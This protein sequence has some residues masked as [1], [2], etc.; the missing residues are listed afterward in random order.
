MLMRPK[1][2]PPGPRT[3]APSVDV[4]A[5]VSSTLRKMSPRGSNVC[6]HE[7]ICDHL[8]YPRT[9]QARGR[10][11]VESRPESSRGAVACRRAAASAANDASAG[12][13]SARTY[14]S[15]TRSV[16]GAPS[17]CLTSARLRREI[18]HRKL[19]NLSL[20]RVLGLR[21]TTRAG[22]GRVPRAQRSANRGACCV[23]ARGERQL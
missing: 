16:R 13:A 14:T 15:Y 21:R 23:R 8:S 11:Q 2:G 7:E 12:A 17:N 4:D 1:R 3:I 22:A 6:T 9:L 18:R 10:T 20:Q 5:A 19:R